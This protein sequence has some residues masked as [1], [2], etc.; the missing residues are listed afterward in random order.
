MKLFCAYLVAVLLFSCGF[1]FGQVVTPEQATADALGEEL[2][3]EVEVAEGVE[4]TAES[5]ADWL[6]ITGGSSGIGS[7]TVTY[8]VSRNS[9]TEE[10]IAQIQVT[11]EAEEEDDLRQSY[12]QIG[13]NIFG[14]ITCWQF[15]SPNLP[16]P[17]CNGDSAGDSVSLSADGR[18]VAFGARANNSNGKGAG[19]ARVFE[20][21]GQTWVQV[22]QTILGQEGVILGQQQGDEAGRKVLLSSDGT[23]VA[24]ISP[25]HGDGFVR[26]GQVRVFELSAG[27]WVQVGEDING[28]EPYGGFGD[29]ISMNH[30][31]SLVAIGADGDNP[32]GPQSGRVRIF[33]FN[34]ADWV[35]LGQD[36]NG[37]AANDLFGDSVFMNPNGNRVAVGA[38]GGGYVEIF[39]LSGDSWNQ[40]GQRITEEAGEADGVGFG[41]EVAMSNNGNRV[42]IGAPIWGNEGGVAFV[43]LYELVGNSWVKIGP[44][45]ENASVEYPEGIEFGYRFSMNA[46]GDRVGIATYMYGGWDPARPSVALGIVQT[47]QLG[48]NEWTPIGETLVEGSTMI[49]V[50]MDATG[51]AIALGAPNFDVGDD[52]S[53]NRG[54]VRIYRMPQ[55]RLSHTVTQAAIDSEADTDG[56]GVLDIHETGTGVFVD[57]NDT[58]SDPRVVDSDGDGFEDGLEVAQGSNPNDTE[59][60]PL[61]LDPENVD[62]DPLGD[63]L[64]FAVNGPQG[65]EWSA[66]SL[67]DWLTITGGASG[68]G[69]GTVTYMVDRNSSTEEREAQIQVT[70]IDEEE[71]DWTGNNFEWIQGNFT[72]QEAKADAEARGGRLAI[73]NTPQKNEIA[74]QLS[75]HTGWF[76]LTDE[77]NEG[78][79]R[80]IDGS[81]LEWSSWFAARG[82]PE[83]NGGTS[84]NY[85]ILGGTFGHDDGSWADWGASNRGPYIIEYPTRSTHTVTQPAIAA[86]LLNVLAGWDFTLGPFPSVENF[87]FSG[88]SVVTSGVTFLSDSRRGRPSPGLEARSWRG[89]F[90]PSR[91]YTFTVTNDNDF[92]VNI[93]RLDFDIMRTGPG[94][95]PENLAVRYSQDSFATDLLNEETSPSNEWESKSIAVDGILAPSSSLEFRIIGWGANNIP[96]QGG[97]LVLDNI[98][99]LATL[100][101]VGLLDLENGTIT[102]GETF[103]LGDEATLTATPSA[104]YV[105]SG[106]GGDATGEVNPLTITMDGNKSIGATFTED[107]RDPDEDGLSNYQELV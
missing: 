84:E 70:I 12:E 71:A 72:W 66:E 3:F 91:Y 5:L 36:L 107:T 38:P 4:W 41:A 82:V 78:D 63:S 64:S 14:E 29:A 94:V 68:T 7:G 75:N 98:R 15:D 6:T 18:R 106:W 89:G 50:A 28:N 59:S 42:A 97:H 45:I 65:V 49:S 56:D 54:L 67:A 99:V 80:W 62:A 8:T 22:G 13:Q 17:F 26:F 103:N 61:S 30:D 19:A 101:S 25:G 1:A 79:W 76:G 86:S 44:Q 74:G 46:K 33:A 37:Q 88:S 32:N 81:P 58:G 92:P 104:G 87:G 95:G 10:R 105:F 47:F 35:Q 102:G 2:T 55:I 48:D 9:S 93:S 31:G 60:F 43:Q 21:S 77:E 11:S 69:P 39:E 52:D 20:L 83:P 57:A 34:G 16:D 27:E 53:E 24:V 85:G 90:D 73:L 96:P 40:I 100:V 23:R 51:D